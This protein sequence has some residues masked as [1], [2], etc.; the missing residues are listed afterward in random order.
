MKTKTKGTK[1]GA[2]LAYAAAATYFLSWLKERIER[3]IEHFNHQ[4]PVGTVE[5]NAGLV[6]LLQNSGQW[7]GDSLPVRL[8]SDKGS[9][10]APAVEGRLE[11]HGGGAQHSSGKRRGKDPAHPVKKKWVFTEARKKNLARLNKK[12]YEKKKKK[13]TAAQRKRQRI[14]VARSKAKS[15]GLPMPDLPKAA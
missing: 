9:A 15:L 12:R 3:E 11:S 2:S 4:V 8:P 6:E 10:V 7:P 5:L 14:Y 13:M 1:R